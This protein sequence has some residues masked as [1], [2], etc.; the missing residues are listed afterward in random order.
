MRLCSREIP[1]TRV[2][3]IYHIIYVSLLPVSQRVLKILTHIGVCTY[4][5]GRPIFAV[6]TFLNK[7]CN[8]NPDPSPIFFHCY[9]VYRYIFEYVKNHTDIFEMDPIIVYNNV[10]IGTDRGQCIPI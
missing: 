2:I 6:G 10:Y 4:N 9:N 7:G 1:K 3:T 5:F 8:R